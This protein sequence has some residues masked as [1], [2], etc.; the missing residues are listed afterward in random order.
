M[1]NKVSETKIMVTVK[2]RTAGKKI[3]K[4]VAFVIT[5]N[6]VGNIIGKLISKMNKNDK[7]SEKV[8]DIL[9]YSVVF[10]GRNIKIENEPFKG[11]VIKNIFGG[12]K[13]DLGSAI[14]EE[15][16]DI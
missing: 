7:D 6:V 12:I 13:L 9:K 3:V 10:S 5:V 2:K 8:G 15:D 11:A 16:V 14:I 4:F 1:S